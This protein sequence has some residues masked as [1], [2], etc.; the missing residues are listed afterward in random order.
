MKDSQTE[1][2][3]KKNLIRRKFIKQDI[4]KLK[5]RASILEHQLADVRTQIND[6][7]EEFNKLKEGIDE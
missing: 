7:Y 1:L 3:E 2:R 4:A 6:K 5:E